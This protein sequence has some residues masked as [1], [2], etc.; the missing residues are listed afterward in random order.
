MV[1]SLTTQNGIQ[2]NKNKNSDGM[3]ICPNYPSKSKSTK[4]VEV[5]VRKQGDQQ[6]KKSSYVPTNNPLVTQ[7]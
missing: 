2:P 7:K 1:F 4:N 3:K 5:I 6:L